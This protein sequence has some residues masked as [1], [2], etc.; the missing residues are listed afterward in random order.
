M[1]GA[2]DLEVDPAWAWRDLPVKGL[3]FSAGLAAFFLVL[4]WIKD[5]LAE[6]VNGVVLAFPVILGVSTVAGRIVWERTLARRPMS[7][8]VAAAVGV[9]AVALALTVLLVLW[10]RS[11]SFAVDNMWPLGLVA[12]GCIVAGK[13]FDAVLPRGRAGT[14]ATLGDDE[15]L[16]VLAG[17]LRLRAEMS[18]RRVRTIAAEAQAHAEEAG[19]SL[20]DEFGRPEDYASTFAPDQLNR[21]R[22]M[23]WV[24]AALAVVSMLGALPP[25]SDWWNLGFALLFAVFALHEWRELHR[26]RST[27]PEQRS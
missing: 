20:Q 19:S 3:Y 24:Y 15:W 4:A 17:V 9:V 10:G 11:S 26:N 21:S 13:G 22:R 16:R 14:H 25:G 6:E 2:G 7:V 12:L 18:E 27:P 5:D 1:N 23:L 8:A